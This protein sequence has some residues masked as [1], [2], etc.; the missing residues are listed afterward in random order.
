MT[1]RNNKIMTKKGTDRF[2]FCKP[3]D[4][5]SRKSSKWN[6]ILSIS[7]LFR[8]KTHNH[9]GYSIS[10]VNHSFEP[11]QSYLFIRIFYA[12]MLDH[13]SRTFGWG[14]LSLFFVAF[15]LTAMVGNRWDSIR[16][17]MT[18]FILELKD[19]CWYAM[20]ISQNLYEFVICDFVQ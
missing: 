12:L 4:T 10:K 1:N 19:L 15:V 20:C 13:P 14:H 18:T 16:P 2:H 3:W 11:F 8:Q 6:F 7:S 17:I 9:V 5:I